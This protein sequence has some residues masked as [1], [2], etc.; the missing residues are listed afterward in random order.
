MKMKDQCAPQF[1]GHA[2]KFKS[3]QDHLLELYLQDTE[4]E[5]YRDL[6]EMANNLFDFLKE[7]DELWRSLQVWSVSGM[8]VGGPV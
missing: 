3:L 7:K 5:F 2:A 6:S 8:G 4:F 1:K